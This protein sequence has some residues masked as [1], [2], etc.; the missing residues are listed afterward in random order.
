VALST[1]TIS[2]ATLNVAGAP[3][4]GRLIISTINP[5]T[6]PAF[7]IIKNPNI[8]YFY[9]D[10]TNLTNYIT[11]SNYGAQNGDYINIVNTGNSGTPATFQVLDG[12][13]GA[14][15]IIRYIYPGHA[16][17]VA[18]SAGQWWPL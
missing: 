11:I 2:T 8:S 7:I 3:I 4:S 17:V 10:Y 12:S 16:G 5:Q 9:A 1:N 6:D 13:T 18:Y 14:S 15:T